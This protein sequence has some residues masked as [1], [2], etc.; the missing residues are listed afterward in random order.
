MINLAEQKSVILSFSHRELPSIKL[1][2][3]ENGEEIA[4]AS[5]VIEVTCTC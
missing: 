3:Q 4:E 1:L 5:E 2:T